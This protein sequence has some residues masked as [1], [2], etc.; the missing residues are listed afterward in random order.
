M[1]L[2]N[3]DFE[4]EFCLSKDAYMK[5]YD[6]DGE[7]WEK[8]HTNHLKLFHDLFASLDGQQIIA[9]D[10]YVINLTFIKDCQSFFDSFDKNEFSQEE[11]DFLKWEI[12]KNSE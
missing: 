1:A 4:L 9:E 10:V 12:F 7:C 6:E 3:H 8:N 11:L 5:A 2:D